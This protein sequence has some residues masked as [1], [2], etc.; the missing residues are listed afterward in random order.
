MKEDWISKKLRVFKAEYIEAQQEDEF[1]EEALQNFYNCN[2]SRFSDKNAL[3][4]ALNS[5]SL[6]SFLNEVDEYGLEEAIENER[7]EK[8]II[9]KAIKAQ[10]FRSF[11]S[12]AKSYF[13]NDGAG[14]Y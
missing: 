14:C 13:R 2:P 11:W 7:I 3:Q 9:T 1:I 5:K 8:L 10:N 12:E 4:L 6:K